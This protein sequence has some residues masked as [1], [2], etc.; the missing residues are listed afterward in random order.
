MTQSLPQQDVTDDVVK[1]NGQTESFVPT[2]QRYTPNAANDMTMEFMPSAQDK[3]SAHQRKTSRSTLTAGSK[4]QKPHGYG[5]HRVMRVHARGGMGQISIARDENLKREVA[6][7]ELFESAADREDIVQR[8]LDEAEITARLEHPGIV[9]VHAFGTDAQDKPYYTMKLVRGKTFHEAIKAYHALPEQAE[10]KSA[11]FRD[12]IRRCA[13][14]CQTMNFA[15]DKGIIHRDLKPANIM[16]GEHGETLIMD[17]GLAKPFSESGDGTLGDLAAEKLGE[18]PEITQQGNVVGT[19]VYMPPEQAAGNHLLMNPQSD[20]YSLGAILYQI[21]TNELPYSGKSSQEIVQKVLNEVPQKPSDVVKGIPKGLEA[22][23]LK[24]MAREQR[25][26]YLTASTI[27]RD[28][29]NWLDDEPISVKRDTRMEKAWRWMRKNRSLATTIFLS[30][31]TLLIVLGA[32]GMMLERAKVKT[33]AATMLA[34]AMRQL[35]EEALKLARE[36]EK[37]LALKEIE[38]AE[39]RET[40]AKSQDSSEVEKQ[41]LRKRIDGLVEETNTLRSEINRLRIIAA[42]LS[43]NEFPANDLDAI[44]K[45]MLPIPF[46]INA[47]SANRQVEINAFD[48]LSGSVHDLLDIGGADDK[49][50]AVSNS[51]NPASITFTFPHVQKISGLRFKYTNEKFGVFSVEIADNL[52]DMEAKT[53]SYE[54]LVADTL[55]DK[56]ADH[57]ESIVVFPRTIDLR[58]I[59]LTVQRTAGNDQVH[60][61]SLRFWGVPNLT[62]VEDPL[63]LTEDEYSRVRVKYPE[64]E[65]TENR[66]DYNVIVLRE[67]SDAELRR[68]ITIAGNTRESDLI[69]A[70]ATANDNTITLNGTEI[71]INIK[72][73]ER[74]SVILVSLGDENLK[75]DADKKSRVFVLSP[76]SEAKIAGLTMMNGFEGHGGVIFVVDASLNVSKTVFTGNSVNNGGGGA[77]VLM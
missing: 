42:E 9:P 39:A 10:N 61:H 59:R 49:T 24:A 11:T 41:S 18:R 54:R 76:G 3:P 45:Y 33:V 29:T 2:P 37:Q 20:I 23:C 5:S 6:L 50:F 30:I 15:H 36:K 73:G 57:E 19:P 12:L 40:L 63:A 8:F 72:A 60:L 35:A 27:F 31:I 1:D 58:V 38:L 55:L 67:L 51:V 53:D 28:L 75:I 34:D 22:I 13:S 25:D 16:L 74:G 47:M 77:I 26:R 62:E 66:S 32:S 44:E 17:W 7:K 48:T 46:D 52:E 64:L 65:L 71:A 43:G 56:E 68:A 69:I 4:S 70:R 14:V 21:L